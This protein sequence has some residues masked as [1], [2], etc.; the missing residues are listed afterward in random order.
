MGTIDILARP[1]FIL[2]GRSRTL[3][4]PL[5]IV[6]DCFLQEDR[7]LDRIT[8][9]YMHP[10]K[11]QDLELVYTCSYLCNLTSLSVILCTNAIYVLVI[12][13]CLRKAI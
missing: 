9:E 6:I 10:I 7:L 13:F 3:A 8:V 11:T 5:V 2:F 1:K 12:S 4:L